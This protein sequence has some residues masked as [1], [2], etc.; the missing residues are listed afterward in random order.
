[1]ECWSGIR[2]SK[3]CEAGQATDTDLQK[4]ECQLLLLHLDKEIEEQKIKLAVCQQ[5]IELYQDR[6]EII[7]GNNQLN[8]LKAA[9][10]AVEH[11]QQLTA[12]QSTSRMPG[13]GRSAQRD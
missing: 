1:M 4:R 12:S 5:K 13:T 8:E 7:Q 2:E 3:L 11:Q 9:I 10:Q 6:L